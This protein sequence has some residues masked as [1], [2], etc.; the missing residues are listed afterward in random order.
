MSSSKLLLLL[1]ICFQILVSHFILG[2]CTS[3]F[4]PEPQPQPLAPAL[5]V[6]GDSLFDSG[7]NNWLPTLAKANYPPYGHNFPQ[8]PTGRFTNG[9]TVVDF[10]AEALGL[11]YPPP[12]AAL[13]RRNS[14]TG[15]NYASGSC[16]ILPETG[17]SIGLCLNLDVQ[18]KLF[19]KTVQTHLASNLKKPDQVAQHLAKSIF[20]FSVGNNDY[21]N[22][23]FNT[24]PLSRRHNYNPQ[25]F[26]ELLVDAL[27][28]KL[29]KL[30]S[31]GVRKFV[32]FELGPI[33]CIPSIV[34]RV[35]PNG[36]CDENKNQIVSIFNDKL[37]LMMKN[38][39]ST[40]QDSY[41]IVGHA[42]S[43]GYDAVINPGNYD[44]SDSNNPCCISWGN[45]TFSCIPGEK[46]CE[47]PNKH[48]FWDGYHLTQATC[49]VIASRCINGSDVCLPLN[50]QQ[51]VQQ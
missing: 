8:G 18:V 40:R 36:K 11:P 47:A 45:G 41:F 19:Q 9:M 49:S 20:F 6:F 43:L 28:L 34:R 48:Y 23:Y 14:L 24:F 22:N 4:S 30:Y 42:H 15:Y 3:L 27:S 51:L 13:L 12:Y 29:Q 46:P 32:V 38:L 7:N 16:G 5:Y 26:A 33:G 21:I 10:V 17:Q 31:L 25:Q 39:T 35:K 50:I 1:F 2:E 37:G 44:L